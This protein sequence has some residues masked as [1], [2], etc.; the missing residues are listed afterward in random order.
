[1]SRNLKASIKGALSI[2]FSK[3]IYLVVKGFVVNVFLKSRLRKE[4]RLRG[5]WKALFVTC[6]V[7]IILFYEV[8]GHLMHQ[9]EPLGIFEHVLWAPFLD[10]VFL[11]DATP[12]TFGALDA[13]FGFTNDLFAAVILSYEFFSIYRRFVKK[14]SPIKTTIEDV[15]SDIVMASWMGLRYFAEIATIVAYS[16][17]P[18]IAQYWFVSYG[19]SQLIGSAALPWLEISYALWVIAGVFLGLL[20]ALIPFTK[21]WHIAVGPVV[22]TKNYVLEAKGKAIPQ[23]RIRKEKALQ[24]LK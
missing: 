12:A 15:V 2:I 6:Y 23:E 16:V 3:D 22:L 7:L 21:L 1:M 18:S 9:L 14:E 20:V 10:I 4:S 13:F 8:K 19:I 5:W 11:K 24:Y 17:P